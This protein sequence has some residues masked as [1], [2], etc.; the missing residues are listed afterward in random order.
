MNAILLAII[1]AGCASL[2]N[3]FFRKCS[4]TNAATYQFLFY[5]YLSS[6][7]G[8]FLIRPDLIL[9]SWNP[10]ILMIGCGAGLLNV[11][12]M[13]ITSRALQ[14]TSAGITF[15][16][17]NASSVFPNLVLFILLGSSYGFIVTGHQIAGMC[18]ILVGLF[19]GIWQ[20]NQEKNKSSTWLKYALGCCLVQTVILCI[21]QS[22]FL[23]FTNG[24]VDDSDVW[25]MVGFFGM[26]LLFQSFVLAR[27]KLSLGAE[28]VSDA[29][30]TKSKVIYG[31]LS[32]MANAASTYLLLQAIQWA[33]PIESGLVFPIFAVGV[34]IL[35]N[36]WGYWLYQERPKTTSIALCSFG[37]FVA[38]LG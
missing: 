32:G 37:I 34:I 13:I 6:F 5:Y 23:F 4:A 29:I 7:A 33:T 20:N 8:S 14:H 25:F 21:F 28:A 38:S 26:A 16:F 27:Q 31:G 18:L 15:T 3:L 24:E 10:T 36:L 17:Q 30:P 1:A 9:S 2:S 11:F 19:A 12:M 22:R 35:C